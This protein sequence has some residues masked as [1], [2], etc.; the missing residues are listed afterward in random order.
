MNYFYVKDNFCGGDK[1][2]DQLDDHAQHDFHQDV[3]EVRTV[4]RRQVS[5]S[6]L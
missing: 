4:V 2:R 5:V 6:C 1:G 3:A